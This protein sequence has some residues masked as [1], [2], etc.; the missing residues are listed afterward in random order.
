MRQKSKE[1]DRY[2]Q[3]VNYFFSCIITIHIPFHATQVKQ[4][5]TKCTNQNQLPCCSLPC[6]FPALVPQQPI[7][8][9][10]GHSDSLISHIYLI[11]SLAFVYF[12]R[13]CNF[14]KTIVRSSVIF[15]FLVFLLPVASKQ[16]FKNS[17]HTNKSN[18]L[19]CR[20]FLLSYSL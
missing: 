3:N 17:F 9:L 20:S 2:H 15:L 19:F 5:K 7:I 8:T 13:L 11:Y 18:Q 6:H 14:M 1:A 10:P 12:P 4:N 16:L